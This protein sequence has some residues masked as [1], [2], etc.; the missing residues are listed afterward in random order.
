MPKPR[1]VTC[2]LARKKTSNILKRRLASVADI[3]LGM[4]DLVGMSRFV[5]FDVNV[6]CG[7]ECLSLNVWANVFFF[8]VFLYLVETVTFCLDRHLWVVPLL[9]W[10]CLCQ[11]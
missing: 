8:C 7:F 2:R 9:P 1:L 10:G 4:G 3:I 11:F 5:C 6:L